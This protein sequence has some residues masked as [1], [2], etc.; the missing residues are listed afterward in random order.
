VNRATDDR[1]ILAVTALPQPI[2]QDGHGRRAGHFVLRPEVAADDRLLADQ[3][4]TVGRHER[5]RIDLGEVGVVGEIGLLEAGRRETLERFGLFA[6]VAEIGIRHAGEPVVAD[7]P[8][9]KVEDAVALIEREPFEQ[10]GVGEREHR[11]VDADA[12]RQRHQRHERQP[13][14]PDQAPETEAE[15]LQ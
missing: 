10:D 8:H 15:V 2:R 14:A 9:Q 12:E 11:G 13:G 1:R 6:P 4:K 5:C 3:A 7:V